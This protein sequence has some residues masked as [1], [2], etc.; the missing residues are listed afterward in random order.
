MRKLYY[1]LFAILLLSNNLKAQKVHDLK[2]VS[3]YPH[4]IAD[5]VFGTW[6]FSVADYEFQDDKLLLLTYEKSLEH[7]KVVLI[8]GSQKVISVLAFVFIIVPII[9]GII[10]SLF[11]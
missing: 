9:A 6:K 7:A 11:I 10:L 3:V 8:D 4:P 5:T 2:P 1:L